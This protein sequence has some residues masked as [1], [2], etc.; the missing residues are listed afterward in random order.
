MT[1]TALD[2]LRAE[3][4][5]VVETGPLMD[6]VFTPF[7]L[8]FYGGMVPAY[9]PLM[10]TAAFDAV[11][12]GLQ[13]VLQM[14]D[15]Q[16]TP[17]SVEEARKAAQGFSITLAEAMEGFDALVTPAT[18]GHAPVSQ[19]PGT[20]N[21]AETQ[22]WIGNTFGFNV[23]RRPGGVTMAGNASD[24][25]PLALQIIGHQLDD[26]RTVELTAWAEDVLGFDPIAPFPA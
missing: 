19:G 1:A 24:G 8:L 2:R 14:A 16:L 12:P 22:A 21:G 11:T 4:V 26:V 18:V 15:E 5:E 10:G 25:M 6:G 23:T 13:G 3:G 17:D 7:L 9:R 20:V